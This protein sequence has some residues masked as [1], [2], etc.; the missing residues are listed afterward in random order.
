MENWSGE[1][2]GIKGEQHSGSAGICDA[3][4]DLFLHVNRLIRV[5]KDK[6]GR[7]GTP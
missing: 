1:W 5:V 2:N 4:N 6:D 7:S 3:L